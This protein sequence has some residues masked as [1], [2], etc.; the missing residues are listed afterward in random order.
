MGKQ[1][2]IQDLKTGFQ[3]PPPGFGPT[4]FLALNDDLEPDRLKSALKLFAERG[5]AGVFMHPRTG[6]EV[7]YLS[8]QWWEKIGIIVDECQ[9]LG[10]KAW[11]YDEY[12]WP[13]GPAGGKALEKNPEFVMPYLEYVYLRLKG[14]SEIDHPGSAV[15]AFSVGMNVK[16]LSDN[17]S[18]GRLMLPGHTGDVLLFFE[19]RVTD[20]TFATNNAP[21]CPPVQGYLDLMNPEAVRAFIELTHQG[22]ADRF[23]QHLGKTIPGVF[24][25]EPQFYRGFPW[26][27][28]LA[29]AF[30][31]ANGYDLIERLYMLVLDRQDYKKLRCDFYRLVEDLC[32]EA[33]YGQIRKW[34]DSY[35]LVFTGHLG[36]EERLSQLAINHGGVYKP[37]KRMSMPGIDALGDGNPVAGGLVN[38]E[39]PNFSPRAAVSIS[40]VHADGRVLCEAGGGA[41]WKATPKSLKRQLDWLFASG[42]NF[43]NPHQSLL[44]IKGLRKRD[45]PPTHF[46]QEPWFEYYLE[47][48]RYTARMSMIS[49]MTRP[50]TD[51]ALLFPGHALR[52]AQAGR[53][54]R[55][56]REAEN[57]I[58]PFNSIMDLLIYNQRDFELV[59]EEYA[60]EESLKVEGGNLSLAG[61]EIKLLVVPPCPVIG[62]EMAE[63]IRRLLEAGG[64]VLLFDEVPSRDQSGREISDRILGPLRRATEQGRAVQLSSRAGFS[65]QGVLAA[66]DRLCE[67]AVSIEC[68]WRD[69]IVLSRYSVRGA[70]LY[71]L[72]DLGRAGGEAAI[73]FRDKRGLIEKWDPVSGKISLIPFVPTPEGAALTTV[74]F[75]PGESMVLVFRDADEKEKAAAEVQSADL[76]EL[77]MEGQVLKGITQLAEVKVITADRELTAKS[78][79]LPLP[80]TLSPQWEIEPEN[81]N[82]MLVEPWNVSAPKF[83]PLP[84]SG[85]KKERYFTART[86]RVVRIGRALIALVEAA[87]PPSRRY[88]TERYF[89]FGGTESMTGLASRIIGIDLERYGLYESIGIMQRISD[90][91]GVTTLMRSY[92]PSGATYRAVATF[93]AA[94]VPED[95][96]LVYED[97]GEPVSFEVNGKSP[98]GKPREVKAWDPCCRAL[99]VADLV[100]PGKN[101][102]VMSGRQPDFP[103]LPPNTHSLEPVAL[104]GSFEVRDRKLVRSDGGAAVEGDWKSRGYPF[105]S[106]PMIYRCAV[107]LPEEYL[108]HHLVLELGGVLE[109][110]ALR[111]NG[112]DAGTRVYPPFKWPVTGLLEAGQNRIELRVVNTAANFFHRPVP[113]GVKAPLRIVP[114]AIHRIDLGEPGK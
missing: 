114:Y 92:P 7:P 76:D 91:L 12:N 41:G 44:S 69:E 59:F 61:R 25:D 27:R 63:L 32:A 17:I 88:R 34:C 72:A 64:R 14:E 67:P 54:R 84:A 78:E 74:T 90:Y 100:R 42:V 75:E 6:L 73:R 98:Q 82:V 21:W 70:D 109:C 26:T 38:M 60:D 3:N 8:G 80:I 89:D 112:K 65:R 85:M 102:V 87:Y 46:E 77:E 28:G 24:T 19:D 18:Q 1:P 56:G 31:E 10:I 96:L 43:I 110:A 2:S 29:R 95:L 20:A 99:E 48:A 4:P 15:A 66:L 36:M 22:Y 11:I 106:G 68:P 55:I 50:V 49:A 105:Y 81:Q 111:V 30:Q 51:T 62:S 71:F 53:G 86:R 93:Q 107:N 58:F 113:S 94:Y 9:R 103:A 52:A 79:P 35:G 108:A 5:C 101:K 97:L 45:F 40:R 57:I 23:P 83:K 13:S 37:L 39:S 33:F 104:M 16:D 47:H